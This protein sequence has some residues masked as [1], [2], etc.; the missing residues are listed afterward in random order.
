[1]RAAMR[2]QVARSTPPSLS[3]VTV[4]EVMLRRDCAACV[5]ISTPDDP[6]SCAIASISRS[7]RSVSSDTVL[8]PPN[9]EARDLPTLTRSNRL[10]YYLKM[11]T[12]RKPTWLER[13]PVENVLCE[14]SRGSWIRPA[15]VSASKRCFGARIRGLYGPVDLAA[16]S[17]PPSLQGS[18]SANPWRFWELMLPKSAADM[19]QHPLDAVYILFR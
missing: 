19:L 6:R 7:K 18:R 3:M 4:S 10:P 2:S 14:F 8:R 13:P 15:G 9:K 17:R 1:M 5:T 11:T 12:G 16:P